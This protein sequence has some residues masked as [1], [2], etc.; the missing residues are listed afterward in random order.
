MS[1]YE[2]TLLGGFKRSDAVISV[3]IPAS[4]LGGILW[5]LYVSK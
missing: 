2:K 4:V 1:E 3:A 5:Y